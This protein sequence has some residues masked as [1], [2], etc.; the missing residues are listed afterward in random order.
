MVASKIVLKEP[1]YFHLPELSL[2]WNCSAFGELTE[3]IPKDAPE[4]LRK[5]V[6]HT[7]YGYAYLMQDVVPGRSETS[8]HYMVNKT[9]I[10]WFSKKQ[11]VIDTTT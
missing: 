2:Y 8:I 6:T 9:A 11:A 7:H 3:M 10:D 5:Y 1:D 4:A